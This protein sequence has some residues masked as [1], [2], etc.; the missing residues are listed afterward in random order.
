VNSFTTALL[1]LTLVAFGWH[2]ML[3]Y[4]RYLQQE[5]YSNARFIRW[6]GS[7][8]AFD[9]RG[10]GVLAIVYLLVFI[11][12]SGALEA[13]LVLAGCALLW[14][15]GYRIEP[16]PTTSGKIRVAMTVRAKKIAW[17]GQFLFTIITLA[18]ALLIC[19]E[20]HSSNPAYQSLLLSGIV[21]VQ[22][23]PFFLII[24]NLLLWP[25]EAK[26]QRHFQKEAEDRL[27]EI[28]PITIGITGSYGKTGA[29]AAL[30]ELLTQC[31]G[32]TFWPTQG[33]NTVMGITRAI[34]ERLSPFHRFAVIEMGAYHIG[35]IKRLC[36][37]TPPRAALVTS[38]GIMHLERFGSAENVYL[39]KS[40]LAQAVPADGILVCNGDSPNA[41]RMAVEHPRKTTL[42]YGLLPEAGHLD[43]Y[44]SDLVFSEEGTSFTLHWKQHTIRARTPLL[45]RPALL[46]ALGAFTMTCALGADPHYAA[47]CLANLVPIDNRLVYDKH[48][49]V[50]YLRDAYNSNPIGFASAL[51]VLKQIPAKRRILMT[52]GMIEL[53]T[54]QYEENKQAGALAAQI[55]DLV[56]IVGNTNR[57]ALTE[58][59]RSK[60]YA[61]ENIYLFDTR[62]EAFAYIA[63]HGMEGDLVLLEND[64]GDLHE[65]K[66][67]F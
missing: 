35:S 29:K 31:L 65:G 18:P 42:L 43:T 15:I 40:E 57:S 28:A 34:R 53:G 39:A 51:E 63:R 12:S 30:G 37:F 62:D 36:D 67:R 54:A 6:I 5:G 26:L 59:L 44:A 14:F 45:G 16:N 32:P 24:A 48:P 49:K 60:G 13:S 20:C 66:V 1:A 55:A 10:T 27:Q 7:N 3:S 19:R 64:L 46:N 50:S 17:V 4:L 23:V 25:F 11:I 41:R 61:E 56:F 58:G 33:I 9:T 2:R 38:V 22:L 8:R 52:P 47:A 21:G